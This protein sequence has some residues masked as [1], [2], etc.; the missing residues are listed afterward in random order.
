MSLYADMAAT[1]VRP[2]RISPVRVSVILPREES[3]ALLCR[4][5]GSVLRS[6]RSAAKGTIQDHS[7]AWRADDIRIPQVGCAGM[8]ND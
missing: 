5:S 6:P 1:V 2:D 4:G 3:V 7:R 8:V